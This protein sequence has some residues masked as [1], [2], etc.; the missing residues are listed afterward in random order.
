MF[1]FAVDGLT[2]F[3]SLP[4]K[5][6]LYLGVIT[7]VLSFLLIVI[8]LFT[9]L[10]GKT[11]QGW[12]SMQMTI[13]FFSGIQLFALGIMGQYLGRIF[14]EVRNRPYYIIEETNI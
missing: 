1:N 4:L 14:D 5:L 8:T 7:S 3:S 9:Y 10:F 2:S 13:L 12:T 11:V 6:I